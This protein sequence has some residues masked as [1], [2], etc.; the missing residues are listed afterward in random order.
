MTSATGSLAGKTAA[1]RLPFLLSRPT[2]LEP[3]RT[4]FKHRLGQAELTFVPSREPPSEGQRRQVFLFL[5][6]E[7]LS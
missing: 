1:A 3:I 7:S 4:A 2:S 5:P 6:G